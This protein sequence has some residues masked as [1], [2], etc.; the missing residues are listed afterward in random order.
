MCI[1]SDFVCTFQ[2]SLVHARPTNNLPFPKKTE[3]REKKKP[4]RKSNH[5]SLP[6]LQCSLEACAHQQP[7]PHEP[8][9]HQLVFPFCRICTLQVTAN[10]ELASP[11]LHTLY[12]V[13][14]TP[15]CVHSSTAYDRQVWERHS[16]CSSQPSQLLS[17]AHGSCH[18]PCLVSNPH[19]SLSSPT[20]P[21]IQIAPLV[22]T[23]EPYIYFGSPARMA[24]LRQRKGVLIS[25]PL[26]S[27]SITLLLLLSSACRLVW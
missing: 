1:L 20:R 4:N 21:A 2:P 12:S 17:T 10:T 16:P 15:Y 6:F 18:F 23:A 24:T 3:K 13:L 19:R 7:T 9:D 22:R 25:Q 5:L 8:N 27:C 26:V 14:P 11:W